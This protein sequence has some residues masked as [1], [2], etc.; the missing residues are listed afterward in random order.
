[1]TDTQDQAS[2]AKLSAMKLSQLQEIAGQIG[3]KGTSRLRKGELI[4]AIRAH[5]AKAP[6]PSKTRDGG[7][8]EREERKQEQ[9][10]Q[11]NNR[12]GRGEQPK[13]G[14]RGTNQ[15]RGQGRGQD[16]KDGGEQKLD[17]FSEFEGDSK[18]DAAKVASLDDIQLPTAE[19]ED[20]GEANRRR[21]G[22]D[23][24][25][26][27][28]RPNQ[29]EGQGYDEADVTSADELIP[30]AG[31][32]D[33]LDNYAFVRTTGYL[34][35]ASDV[36]VN[37]GMVRR[38][39]LRRGDAITG[40]VKQPREGE[41]SS[42]Q[43]F[44]ALVAPELV[45]NAPVAETEERPEFDDLPAVFPDKFL[46][47]GDQSLNQKMVDTLAPLGLGSRALVCVE[48]G[49]PRLQFLTEVAQGIAA[50]QPEVHL[51]VILIDERPE[52]ATY[53]QRN[54]HGEVIASSFDRSGND[55]T[56]VAGLGIE[57][58]KRLVELG[59][60]VVVIF[61]S[62]TALGRAHHT[63]TNPSSRILEHGWDA[64]TLHSL[65]QL[66]GAGRNIE[67]GGSLTLIATG[68]E[69]TK[70]D[71]FVLNEL[72]PV[73]N[74]HI[75]LSA[76]AAGVAVDPEGTYTRNLEAIFDADDVIPRVVLKRL[77]ADRED[78]GS[79]IADQLAE[80]TSEKFLTNSVKVTPREKAEIRRSLA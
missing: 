16:Q 8:G 2:A 75:H 55:H 66:F 31:V 19:D 30:I 11:R 76:E 22:R 29:R 18:S 73:A 40:A 53:M 60:D 72:R 79:W 59:Q 41:T 71:E 28:R 35:G 10:T 20:A 46:A 27:K 62:V 77:L 80:T 64:S 74:A 4:E 47:L 63:S 7:E 58:A 67:N 54:I 37:L 45:N 13:G 38:H 70:A 36:Y 68:V 43:K 14:N 51:M 49:A 26:R 50:S 42:R 24:R 21:R 56:T 15:R 39:S 34:P 69:A 9:R 65:K 44:N 61:D 48:P 1:M 57:R 78:A 5:S 23:R 25:D 17:V 3:L 32:L 52:D 12:Q 6:E 33:V